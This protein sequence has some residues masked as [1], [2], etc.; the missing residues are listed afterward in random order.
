MRMVTIIKT[1]ATFPDLATQRGDFEDWILEGLGLT[2][3]HALICDVTRGDTLPDYH[4]I[5]GIIITGSHAMVTEHQDWCECTA[6]WLR[7]VAQH[8]IPTLGICYGHQLLAYAFGGE[9]G[10][11]NSGG[12]FGTIDITLSKAA[13]ADALFG[14]MPR[15]FKAHV[16][17]AQSVLTLPE[18]A[19]VLAYSEHE[20]YHAFVINKNMWGVQFHPEFDREIMKEYIDFNSERITLKG[21]NPAVLHKRCANTPIAHSLLKRFVSIL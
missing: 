1:G 21:A 11:N 13:G 6:Q 14:E 19:Q 7:S 15:T 5:S 2:K 10:N 8:S 20:R 18:S 16:S 9:V 4:T 12:E 3:N 17:H